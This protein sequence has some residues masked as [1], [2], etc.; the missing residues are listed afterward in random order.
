MGS[1]NKIKKVGYDNPGFTMKN[2]EL[3]SAARY[4][5]PI[6]MN[7]DSPNKDRRTKLVN[8][9]NTGTS[10]EQPVEHTHDAPA[11]HRDVWI[12]ESEREA[13]AKHNASKATA[14]HFGDPHGPKPKETPAKQVEGD[15]ATYEGPK[16]KAGNAPG[17]GTAKV[18]VEVG[19]QAWKTADKVTKATKESKT[20]EAKHGSTGRKI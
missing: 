9:P 4:G 15:I 13:V 3:A 5:T 11:K 1:P 18:A 20:K 6:Q 10:R 17:T 12:V 19:K 16:V 2:K 7:Y 14:D 8:D